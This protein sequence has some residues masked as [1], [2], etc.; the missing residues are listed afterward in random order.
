[1]AYMDNMFSD[2]I[3]LQYININNFHDNLTPKGTYNGFTGYNNIFNNVPDDITI[4]SDNANIKINNEL[5]NKNCYVKDCSINWKENKKTKKNL[6]EQC[7]NNCIQN[8]Y[9]DYCYNNCAN[10]YLINENTNKLCKS[11]LEKC[12]ISIKADK[13]KD[14][15]SICN[16][17]YYPKEND[18]LNID[19]Y[20]NCYNDLELQGYYLDKEER[21]YKKCYDSCEK[22][23]KKGDKIMHNCLK[24]NT[25]FPFELY[26]NNFNNN[27]INCYENCSFYYYFD[28]NNDYHCTENY[29]CPEEFNKL[30]KEKR[31]CLAECDN[32][33]EYIY[34]YNNI[35]YKN[36]LNIN[37]SCTEEKPFENKKKHKCVE[38][39][40]Y[41]ELLKKTC[42]LRY[43]S[44]EK[45]K[46]L[47]QDK[48]FEIVENWFTSSNFDFSNINKGQNDVIEADILK[49][50]LTNADNQKNNTNKNETSIDL[51]DCENELR[52][53]YNILDGQSLYIKKIEV[54]YKGM[55]IPKIEYEIYG[56]IN[57]TNLGKLNKS[58]CKNKKIAI[59]IPMNLTENLDKLNLSSPYYNEVCNIAT[60]DF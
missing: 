14:L 27:H 31:F 19:E 13:Y 33:E 11:D 39:C 36:Y 49:I 28:I 59:N 43:I 32:D 10:N 15:C 9:T 45:G 6:I 40:E 12:F 51:L 37:I 38:N 5:N 18:S 52:K 60:S 24:C 26:F 53:F 4:C 20:F 17:D 29:S 7:I 1:M 3:N 50:T 58:I 34:E 2:C 25:N 57:G 55:K 44:Y 21:L 54:H 41:N 42:V 30:I 56:R 16:K 35:C 47:P 23:E 8:N 46:K 48:I 22:C